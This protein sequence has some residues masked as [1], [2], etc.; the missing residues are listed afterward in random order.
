MIVFVQ[1]ALRS[2]CVAICLIDC[3]KAVCLSVC[4]FTSRFRNQLTNRC[5]VSQMGKDKR[6]D[7]FA[8]DEAVRARG[9][10]NDQFVS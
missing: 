6:T 7:M 4:L 10:K 8:I 2:A 5:R 9:A 3:L 1:T